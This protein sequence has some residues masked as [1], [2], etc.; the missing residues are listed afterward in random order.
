MKKRI[1]I[2]FILCLFSF[3]LNVDAASSITCSDK[4]IEVGDTFTC[5]IKTDEEITVKSSF[6]I[7]KTDGKEKNTKEVIFKENGSITYKAE[8]KGTYK[9]IISND[10]FESNTTV[11]VLDKTTTKKTTTTKKKSDNNSLKSISINNIELK[12]FNKDILLYSLTVENE[13]DKVDVKA[14]KEDNF[15]NVSYNM[16]NYLEVGENEVSIKVTAEDDSIRIYKII[17]TRKREISS[18]ADLKLLNIKGY[19]LKFDGA[20]KTY[21]LKINYEDKKLDIE[22]LTEDENATYEITG[23]DNLKNGSV[24]KINVTAENNE[25]NT[26]RIIISKD[27]KEEKQSI[28]PVIIFSIVI[29]IIL[30]IVFVVLKINKNK[31]DKSNKNNNSSSKKIEVEEE[32][33]KTKTFDENEINVS[34]EDKEL[35]K[36][37]I[38]SINSEKNED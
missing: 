24:I 11:T 21:H 28:I 17:V 2:V 34:N 29:V 31:K 36:T 5:T 1:F 26:Y 32:L 38:I 18:N 13:V 37:K 27:K 25:I 4:N 7:E 16:P 15:A 35:E 30:I 6:K 19:N 23:N 14:V 3:I 10:T 20:S 33:S 22:C 8:S 9:I 12:D